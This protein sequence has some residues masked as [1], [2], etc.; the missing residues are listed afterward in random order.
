MKQYELSVLHTS[1]SL[2]FGSCFTFNLLKFRQKFVLR[3][4]TRRNYISLFFF[5]WNAIWSAPKWPR[6][7]TVF[8][9]YI[10]AQ[11]VAIPQWRALDQTLSNVH[12]INFTSLGASCGTTISMQEFKSLCHCSKLLFSLTQTLR[13]CSQTKML[14]FKFSI[15]LSPSFSYSTTSNH[16]YFLSS[17]TCEYKFVLCTL[18]SICNNYSS[19]PNGLWVNSLWGWRPNGLLTQSPLGR[20]E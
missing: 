20:E 1:Y 13:A 2:D 5:F 17:Y 10:F 7:G 12:S 15:L 14:H 18:Y 19:S 8:E 16:H 6:T 11:T 4:C 3:F 9:G